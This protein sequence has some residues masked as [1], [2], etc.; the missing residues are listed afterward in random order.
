MLNANGKVSERSVAAGLKFFFMFLI[1]T[2]T[3][4]NTFTGVFVYED[5]TGFNGGSVVFERRRGRGNAER[6]NSPVIIPI[7]YGHT[8]NVK[9]ECAVLGCAV[10]RYTRG[11]QHF[12]G[13]VSL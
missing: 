7:C 10:L 2:N 11:A 12:L 9:V 1:N 4:R 6:G 8:R 5:R 3:A 13:W